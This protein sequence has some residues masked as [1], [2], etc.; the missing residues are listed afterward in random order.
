[1]LNELHVVSIRDS[2]CFTLAKTQFDADG[3][4]HDA[5]RAR[6]ALKLTLSQLTWWAR[7][8]KDARRQQP[9]GNWS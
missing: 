5:V 3:R 2:V 7:A 1:M 9:Y 8:L 6:Q 4:I